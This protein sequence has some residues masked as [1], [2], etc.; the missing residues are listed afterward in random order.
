MEIAGAAGFASRS[1][2]TALGKAR[3]GASVAAVGGSEFEVFDEAG[4]DEAQGI[5]VVPGCLGSMMVREIKC[6]G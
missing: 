5:S 6:Y 2:S 3:A 1:S 4:V